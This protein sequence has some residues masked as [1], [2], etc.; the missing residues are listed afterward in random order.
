MQNS[1]GVLA[2]KEIEQKGNTRSTKKERFSYPG[3]KNSD[4]DKP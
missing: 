1:K 2:Y 4:F 3:S